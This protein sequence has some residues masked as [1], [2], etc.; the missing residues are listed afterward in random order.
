MKGFNLA[1]WIGLSL[2]FFCNLIAC[3]LFVLYHVWFWF[4]AL[5]LRPLFY[6]LCRNTF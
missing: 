2:L 6:Y 5:P 3:A 1:I 4:H